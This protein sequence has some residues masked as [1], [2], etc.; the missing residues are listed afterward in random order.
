MLTAIFYTAIGVVLAVVSP[1][2]FRIG[3]ESVA[4]AKDKL[5]GLK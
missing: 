2:V 1:K 3:K 5:D 4:K